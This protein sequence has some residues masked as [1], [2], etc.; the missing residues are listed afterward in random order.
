[1]KSKGLRSKH[2]VAADAWRRIVDLMW[3]RQNF[4][5]QVLREHGLTPGHLKALLVMRPDEPK[6]MGALAETLACD[7]SMATWLVD[8][9][10]ER[11]MVERRTLPTDRRVKTIALTKHGLATRQVFLARLY[12]P[13]K[14]FL[15]ADRETLEALRDALARLPAAE[16]TP[17]S[18]AAA[19]GAPARATGG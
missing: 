1:V 16:P 8:R 2:D 5:A 11:G 3:G 17:D 6:P 13:P 10:E 9:L 15:S 14:E 12:E 4:G 18:P 7:A 19:R